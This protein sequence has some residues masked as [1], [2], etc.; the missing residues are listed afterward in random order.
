M[1]RINAAVSQPSL[2]WDEDEMRE[3]CWERNQRA[4]D[5]KWQH[6]LYVSHDKEAGTS[7]IKSR[8]GSDAADVIKVIRGGL[9]DFV[10]WDAERLVSE[11]R[12]L[13]HMAR[14]GMHEAHYATIR[15][16]K[17]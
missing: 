10:N 2:G 5:A 14:M 17:G 6:W 11:F 4:R 3:W 16:A 8:N 1:G 15:F 9:P 7:S 12:I 13:R